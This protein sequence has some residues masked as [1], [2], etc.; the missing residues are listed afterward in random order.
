MKSVSNPTQQMPRRARRAQERVEAD[1]A[2][3]MADHPEDEW[4]Y[5]RPPIPGEFWPGSDEGLTHTLTIFDGRFLYRAGLEVPP[6]ADPEEY[7]R[8]KVEEYYIKLRERYGDDDELGDFLASRKASGRR[9]LSPFTE[10]AAQEFA[11]W[12]AA[13][14][15]WAAEHGYYPV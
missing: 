5:V 6:G 14:A 9:D 15:A 13:R 11:E 1:V 8:A 2:A 12:R 10:Q 7:A 4:W 3:Y